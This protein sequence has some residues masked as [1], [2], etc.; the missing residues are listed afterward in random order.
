MVPKKQMIVFEAT[1]AVLQRSHWKRFVKK[2]ANEHLQATASISAP[3][4]SQQWRVLLIV[5]SN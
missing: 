5:S 1:E 3:C 2:G 4:N